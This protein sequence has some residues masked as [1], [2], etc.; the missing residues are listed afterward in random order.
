LLL[1]KRKERKAKKPDEIRLIIRR[2][3]SSAYMLKEEKWRSFS[4]NLEKIGKLRR[5]I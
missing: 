2:I 3:I 4:K 5:P 1:I